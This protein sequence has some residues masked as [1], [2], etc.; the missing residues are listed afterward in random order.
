MQNLLSK[1]LMSINSLHLTAKYGGRIRA[2]H[3]LAV[4][5]I[6]IEIRTSK[7]GQLWPTEYYKGL[8]DALTRGGTRHDPIDKCPDLAGALVDL[9]Y[10][11]G[12]RF[13]PA[14]LILL[15]Q[16]DDVELDAIVARRV[17]DGNEAVRIG[18]VTM[19]QTDKRLKF[20]CDFF[21][22]NGDSK[23]EAQSKKNRRMLE[24]Q[25]GP[26]LKRHANRIIMS[27]QLINERRDRDLDNLVDPLIPFFSAKIQA[28]DCVCAVKEVPQPTG[29]EILCI[30]QH[31]LSLRIEDAA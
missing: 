10:E 31:P 1:G 13:Y 22:T 21:D 30:S 11:R 24:V 9:V 23:A 25:A 5:M 15:S 17:G 14:Q 28:L 12:G 26:S 4:V 3:E 18:S 20:T 7:Q 29:K 16:F 19:P 6:G 27:F 8:I 2:L